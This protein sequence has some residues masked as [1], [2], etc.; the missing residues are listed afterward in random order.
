[1][2]EVSIIIGS[3]S[4]I[5]VL[6]DVV[7]MLDEF[8]VSYEKRIL[9]AHRTPDILTNYVKSAEKN[10]TRVFIA[11]AGISAALPGV[12]AS[13]TSKPVIGV[14]VYKSGG[15]FSGMDSL[16][17]IVQMPPGVPVAA[18]S[19]NGG[20]NAAL[21]ALRILALENNNIGSKLVKYS[22]KQKNKVLEKDS[23]L[24]SE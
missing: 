14:P 7:T 4:D 15:A 11:I 13:L 12:V 8:Q 17:S 5:P 6:E 3:D 24:N 22:E 18:V 20:K 23:K 9:S 21:L 10:G 16:L 1:M 2:N 19:V